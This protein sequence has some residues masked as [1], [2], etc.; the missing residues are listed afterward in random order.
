MLI[1]LTNLSAKA[2]GKL[3]IFLAGEQ[4]SPALQKGQDYINPAYY[5]L[6]RSCH[7]RSRNGTLPFP[8]TRQTL[9]LGGTTRE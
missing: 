3:F 7:F 8:L 4:K 1:Y 2:F 6:L 5:H 9:A